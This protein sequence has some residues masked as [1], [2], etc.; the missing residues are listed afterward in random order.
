MRYVCLPLLSVLILL[1]LTAQASAQVE[2]LFKGSQLATLKS[3]CPGPN[4]PVPLIASQKEKIKKV[5]PK[6]TLFKTALV[7]CKKSY[8]DFDAGGLKL[9]CGF[10]DGKMR[11]NDSR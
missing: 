9:R 1:C 3:K 7:T 5:F 8:V 2:L 6:Q 10:E 11:C 4:V